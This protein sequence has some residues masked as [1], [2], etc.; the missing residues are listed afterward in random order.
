MEIENFLE[1]EQVITIKN[2]E[3]QLAI[4]EMISKL[5]DLGMIDNVDRFYAQVI[6]RETLE[7]TGIGHGFAI[8]HARTDSVDRFLSVFGISPVGIEYQSYD[9]QP[10]KYLLLCIFPT[11]MS[12]K[13]LYLVGMMARIFGVDEKRK[14]F[15]EARTPARIYALLKKEAKAYFESISQKDPVG[16]GAELTDLSGVP[17]SNLDLLIRL[18][19]LYQILDSENKT[20]GIE[21]KIKEL[22]RLIDNRSLTYYERMRKKMQNPFAILDKTSCS[23]CHMEL[24][25]FY[26]AELKEG[27]GIPLCNQCGRFLIIL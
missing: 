11:S 5:L 25:P 3:K 9:N 15:D 13:Y 17:A 24:P 16:K 12:T 10:V 14:A 6:H 22:K 26:L 18:D 2:I 27:K 23:G 20:P 21:E 1:R 4:R 19:R 7:N 8:P